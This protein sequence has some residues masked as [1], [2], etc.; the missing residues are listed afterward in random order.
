MRKRWLPDP[1]AVWTDEDARRVLAAW[2]RTSEP[3]ATFARKH[4]LGVNRLYWW[5]K[6]LGGEQAPRLELVPA[7][8]TGEEEVSIVVR[9]ASNVSI[10]IAKASPRLIAEL[11]G[12]LTRA[13]S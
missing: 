12:A 6:R 10:E 8:L 9:V 13:G 3:L 5:R 4:G 11:I 1:E 7:R 2:K